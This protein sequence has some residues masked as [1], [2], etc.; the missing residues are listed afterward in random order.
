MFESYK[1]KKAKAKLELSEVK[2]QLNEIEAPKEKER[3]DRMPLWERNIE[4]EKL[5]LAA[6]LIEPERNSV[7]Y[8]LT[9][10]IIEVL[11]I[12]GLVYF[13][14]DMFSPGTLPYKVQTFLASYYKYFTIF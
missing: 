2:K 14:V 10:S 4:I 11:F 3:W 5:K 9:I 12:L 1:L 7:G 8:R 6:G 13:S